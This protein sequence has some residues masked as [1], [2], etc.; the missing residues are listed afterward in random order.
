MHA[1]R[2]FGVKSIQQNM[3]EEVVM[4]NHPEVEIQARGMPR[5]PIQPLLWLDVLGLQPIDVLG[6]ERGDLSRLDATAGWRNWKH[7]QR[8]QTGLGEFVEQ[9]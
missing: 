6:Y 4:S 2:P 3:S 7:P 9:D 5:C 1:L 8:L